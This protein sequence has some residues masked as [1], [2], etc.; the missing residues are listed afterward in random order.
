M[1]YRIFDTVEKKWEKDNIYLNPEGELFLI[2]Q[3]ILGFVKIPLALSQDRYVYHRDIDLCDKNGVM[4][5]EGDYIR[6]RVAEDRIVTGI[7]TYARELS[8]YI[9]LCTTYD[10]YFTLGTEV[11]EF[12]E[13]IGN[14]FDG[15]KEDDQDGEQ[16][17]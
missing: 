8:S 14:V 11:C 4:I 7:V 5:Y 10:E 9:M 1:I 12:I 13:V 2:K 15:Y 6:A 17:L 3:T 16:T